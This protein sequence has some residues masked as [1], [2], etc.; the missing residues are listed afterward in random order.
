MQHLLDAATAQSVNTLAGLEYDVD[1]CIFL[2]SHL[3][4][5][6]IGI[7]ARIRP[8]TNRFR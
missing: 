1:V 6:D 5:L 2:D 4:G 8:Y 7:Q 3:Q